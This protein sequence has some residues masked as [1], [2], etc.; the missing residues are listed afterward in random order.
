[1]HSVYRQRKSP[2]YHDVEVTM[3]ELQVIIKQSGIVAFVI[4]TKEWSARWSESLLT[5]TDDLEPD[6]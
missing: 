6:E 3:N 5:V 4:E 2:K 1:M